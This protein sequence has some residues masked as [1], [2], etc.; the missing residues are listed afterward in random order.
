LIGRWSGVDGIGYDAF[1]IH[2]SPVT[3]ALLWFDDDEKEKEE[4]LL[5]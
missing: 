2:C 3:H 1:T 5:V 4:G